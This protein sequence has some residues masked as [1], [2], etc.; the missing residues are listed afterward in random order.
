M[1]WRFTGGVIPYVGTFLIF[2]DYMRGSIRL[3][4]LMQT[5]VIYIFTHDSVGVG[6]DGPTHQPVEQPCPCAHSGVDCPPAS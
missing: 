5:K 2:S 6:E 1:A 3:S 4:A